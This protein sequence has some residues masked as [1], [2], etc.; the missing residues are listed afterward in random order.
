MMKVVWRIGGEPSANNLSE[1]FNSPLQR[2]ASGALSVIRSTAMA[3]HMD[4]NAACLM[5]SVRNRDSVRRAGCG[6]AIDASANL[7]TEVTTPDGYSY[8]P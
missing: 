2:M 6:D 1:N 3:F 7:R 4:S 8:T 5:I